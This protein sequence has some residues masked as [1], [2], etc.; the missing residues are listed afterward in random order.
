MLIDRIDVIVP[1]QFR[2]KLV[3]RFVL[4][5][6][7]TYFTVFRCKACSK[8]K[9]RLSR[10]NFSVRKLFVLRFCLSVATRRGHSLM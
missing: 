4:A 8:N 1:G 10:A 9:L 3:T 6:M 7:T 5:K 2:T